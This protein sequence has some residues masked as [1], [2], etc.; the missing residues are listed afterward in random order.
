MGEANFRSS[1]LRRPGLLLTISHIEVCGFRSYGA[2]PQRIELSA[3][4]TVIHADNSQGKTSLAEAFEFLHTGTISRRQLGGGSPGEFEGSLRN[5]HIGPVAE[6][7]VEVGLA[8]ELGTETVVRRVL[9]VDYRGAAEC[10]STLTMNGAGIGSV[11]EVGL[12]LS[13][14]PLAAPVLLDHALRYAVSAKPGDRSNYFKAMLEVADLDILRTEI[15]SVVSER[16]ARPQESLVRN[17]IALRSYSWLPATLPISQVGSEEQLVDFMLAS[18]HAIVPPSPDELPGD[19]ALETAVDRVR[20]ELTSRQNSVVPVRELRASSEPQPSVRVQI[21]RSGENGHARPDN[22]PLAEGLSSYNVLAKAVARSVADVLPLLTAALSVDA[23]AEHDGDG[24]VDCP[25]CRTPDALTADRVA[26]IRQQVADQDGLTQSGSSLRTAVLSLGA[27]LETIRN[28]SAQAAP[29]AAEWTLEQRSSHIETVRQLG[30]DTDSFDLAAENGILV[31]TAADDVR[32]AIDETK[33]VLAR[34]V[35][36][37]EQHLEIPDSDIGDL[38]QRGGAIRQSL[39]RQNLAIKQ[40]AAA[41]TVCIEDVEPRLAALSAT[42]GWA[43]LVELSSKADMLWQAIVRQKLADTCT[44]RLKAAQRVITNAIKKVLDRKLELMAVEIRAWWSMMRPDELT[45]FDRIS[46]R[47]TGNRYLDLTASLVP[48]PASDGVIRNALAVL[49][50]SQVNALGLAAFLARCQILDCPVIF[51]DDPVPGSDREHRL[52]FA[53]SVVQKLLENGRQLIVATHDAELARTLQS[54]HQ[55]VG[56]DEFSANLLDPRVGTRLIRTGDDF[57]RAMLDAASQMSSPLIENR[58]AAG[59]SLRIATE[60]LAKHIL[61]AA[62]ATAGEPAA[63]L[64]DYDN[65]SLKDLRPLVSGHAVAANEPGQWTTLARILNDSD[66]DTDPPQSA[67]L[68]T[69]HSMLRDIKKRHKV[70]TPADAR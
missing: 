24:P 51:L 42:D 65:K 49:S 27:D 28:W 43:T 17:F 55:H 67:D 19:E 29:V 6:V 10:E 35:D 7:Y 64:S 53:S 70:K 22:S 3:P 41:S 63:A 11:S 15:G 13:D 59:N 69:C 68:K 37:L 45:V 39:Q 1:V 50:N 52:T 56:I 12:H 48:D 32:D 18:L 66:H 4:L 47:G 33:P 14:P 62:R 60:R 21:S 57:E 44:A 30:G 26:A 20:H 2:E 23:V 38:A 34:I 9:D 61:V 36:R 46:R 58:R 40:C 25:L 5:A 8:D 16:E 31:K 54:L